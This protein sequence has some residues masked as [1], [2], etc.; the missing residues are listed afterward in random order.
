M[1]PLGTVESGLRPAIARLRSL[2][3]EMFM[4]TEHH[5]SDVVLLAFAAGALDEAQRNALATHVHGCAHCR[6]F[7]HAME[8]IGGIV[9]DGLPPTSLAG[10]SLSEVLARL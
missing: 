3:G 2:L 8:H 4:T 1:I 5:P 9:L 7:V 6:A 10:G